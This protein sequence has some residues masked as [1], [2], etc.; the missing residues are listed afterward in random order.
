[1]QPTI[2]T[3]SSRLL[4][5]AQ[6]GHCKFRGA[7][8]LVLMMIVTGV[9]N[10]VW[11]Q[12]SLNWEGQEGV[13][14]TPLAYAVQSNDKN[15]GRPVVA[16]HYFDGGDVLGGFHQVS[17]TMGALNRIEFGYTR[18]LHREGNTV[19]LSPLWS[20]GFNTF[21]GKVNLLSE[22]RTWRPA[23]AVG[24]VARTQVQNVGGVL[25]GKETHNADF[26]AVFTKTVTQIRN[27]PLVF[28]VGIKATNASLLGLAGNAPGYQGRAFGAFA[29]ALRG[30]GTTT[31][32]FGSEVQQEPRHIEG[33]PTAVVPT[34]ITYVVRFMPAGALP[35]RGWSSEEPKLTFDFGIAQ[36]A[37]NILPGVDLHARRQFALGLSYGF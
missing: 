34:T 15:F 23:L 8:V 29:F 4:P 11:G 16:Y 33:L 20:A 19:S 36:A 14:I 32:L 18:T 6:I 27:L 22:R 13:F 2:L 26:Y 28:N 37:G 12:Q 24:F 3:K 17:V 5:A 10:A 35:L 21:H 25:S 30:P 31:I 7:N 9:C 1:M